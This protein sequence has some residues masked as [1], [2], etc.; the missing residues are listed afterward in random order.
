MELSSCCGANLPAQSRQELVAQRSAPLDLRTDFR[1]QHAAI[2]D[3]PS[4]HRNARQ[5]VTLFRLHRTIANGVDVQIQCSAVV[6]VLPK[7]S[8]K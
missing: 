7:G 8:I 6:Q 1:R 4:D 2:P 3:A 5:A